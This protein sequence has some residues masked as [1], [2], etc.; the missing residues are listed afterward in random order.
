MA[1][2]KS[3]YD[4]VALSPLTPEALRGIEEIVWP[5][6]LAGDYAALTRVCFVCSEAI[7]AR[8]PST[9]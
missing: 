1:S 6:A 3:V 2:R 8:L 7:L 5:Q 4:N 9:P